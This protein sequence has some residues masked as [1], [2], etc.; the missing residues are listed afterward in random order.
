MQE[1]YWSGVNCVSQDNCCVSMDKDRNITANFKDTPACTYKLKHTRN[2]NFE[3]VGGN[4]SASVEAESQYEECTWD[5]EENCDWLDLNRNSQGF[6]YS[7]KGNPELNSRVC[8]LTVTGDSFEK[9][10][11][12]TQKGN[13]PPKSL[14]TKISHNMNDDLLTVNLTGNRSYDSEGDILFYEWSS[15]P[16]VDISFVEEETSS[17]TFN[18]T[19]ETQYYNVILTVID[20][21]GTPGTDEYN[22]TVLKKEDEECL[23]NFHTN[24]FQGVSPLTVDLNAVEDENIINYEWSA[25]DYNKS[26]QDTGINSEFIFEQHGSHTIT[27]TTT[28]A[29]GK[30]STAQEEVTVLMEPI[31]LFD[32]YPNTVKLLAQVTLDANESY[33]YDGKI[34]DYQWKIVD[35]DIEIASGKKTQ[36]AFEEVGE[37][38]IELVVIDNDNLSSIN[39]ARQIITVVDNDADN[40]L[41]TAI[42]DVAPFESNKAPLTIYLDSSSSVDHDGEIIRYQ[43]LSSDEQIIDPEEKTITFEENGSYEITLLVTDDDGAIGMGQES[44]VVGPSLSKNSNFDKNKCPDKWI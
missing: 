43:W 44:I 14:I 29:S 22:V 36:V 16:N 19:E 42:I 10:F 31:A 32:A 6:D 33:D 35:S 26:L 12:V 18:R 20:E 17:F 24:I 28:C 1:V 23:A 30:T 7:A 4:S 41:P 34:F 21:L 8:T 37:Y 25:R 5:I 39:I 3:A 38:E 13:K 2:R 11:F 40:L 9:S 15:E 27:L